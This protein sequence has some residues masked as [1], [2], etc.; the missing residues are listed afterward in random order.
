MMIALHKAESR[1]SADH[2]WLQCN[3]SFSFADY[4]DPENMQ[5]GP[6]RVFNDDYIHPQRG[7][8]THPH[9]DMEIITF[10]LQGQL[11]HEDNTGGKEVLKPGEIQRMSAGTGILHSEINPSADEVTNSLQLW[12]L[13]KEK[14]IKPSY[15]QRTYD[16]AKAKNRLLPVLS[17]RGTFEDIAYLHQDLTIF[18]SELEAGKS[19][20]FTQAPDR[21]T[22]VFVIEGEVN[23]NDNVRLERRDAARITDT[24][25]LSI[26]SVSGG[27][28]ML[29]D[30]P[31]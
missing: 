13:P 9:R 11:Q 26:E 18:I 30:L 20:S 22:Y 1:Y 23:L 15:E 16:Q 29:I 8:G 5:F 19:V 10:V 4:H 14:G 28:F 3:F 7:F 27:T 24:E 25:N 2:G 6:L 31:L 12:F 17:G 21:G